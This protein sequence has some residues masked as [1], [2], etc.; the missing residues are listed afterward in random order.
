MNAA[1]LEAIE[2]K[3]TAAKAEVAKAQGSQET[4]KAQLLKEH[5]VETIEE[6]EALEAKLSEQVKELTARVDED[7]AALQVVLAEAVV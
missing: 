6:A 2:A 4:L 3:I 5:G 7:F 1:Q